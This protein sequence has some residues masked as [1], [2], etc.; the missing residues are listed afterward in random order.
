V[1]GLAAGMELEM[2][3]IAEPSNDGCIIDAIR[4]GELSEDVLDLAVARLLKLLERV[5]GDFAD[6]P[7]DTPD[8]NALAR[9]IAAESIVLLKND[10]RLLPL[11][12]NSKIAFIGEFAEKPRYQGAGSS[13]VNPYKVTSALEAVAK[14]ADVTYC[15]GYD[16]NNCDEADDAL[17]AGA[18]TVAGDVDVCV[19]FI[20]L[21]PAYESEGFDRKHMRLPESHNKLV[22]AITA[23]NPNV[24][25]VL[26]NGSPVEMP[27]VDKASGIVEAYLAG[28]AGG[29]AVID[30]L[31]GASNPCGKLAESMPKKLSDNPSYLYYIGE[32][33]VV[34][35][36][37]GV[38]V[39]Y[40]YYD[41]K[42]MDVLFPFGHGLSYTTFEY[43]NLRLGAKSMKDSDTLTVTANITNTGKVAGKEI[44]Q[45][46]VGQKDK[47]DRLIRPD[48]ELRD[49]TKVALEAGE[50]KKVTFTL[51]KSAFSYYNTEISDWH[52]LSGEYTI[53]L[54]RSS[55]DIALKSDVT[56]TSTKPIPFTAD[57][58]TTIRDIRRMEQGEAFLQEIADNLPAYMNANLNPE[59]GSFEYMRKHAI[60]EMVFRQMRLMG[61]MPGKSIE[62][63][64]KWIDEK[65]NGKTK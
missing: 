52:V 43:S 24:V 58:N 14:I 44:V 5:G 23:A 3:G 9:K 53:M 25:V 55:R 56:M 31:F 37:E 47:D 6:L 54:G 64:Q 7:P 19:V 17:V 34:E 39:G 12:K 45:L 21:P 29:G 22:E 10:G 38:F 61:A 27:W 11:N 42:E 32:R 20:G 15:K 8:N 28:Q 18:V 57:V 35:Y 40:R 65:L 59:P 13:Q 49:F 1:K 4:S 51:G 50:T 16:I 41:A 36:R 62:D 2:P 33:D 30:V 48:K 60:P 63:I 26:Y 46:Y